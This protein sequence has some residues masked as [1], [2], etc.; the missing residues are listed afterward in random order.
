MLILHSYEI[1]NFEILPVLLRG[2]D[3]AQLKNIAIPVIVFLP[4]NFKMLRT[5]YMEF[6][7]VS[8]ST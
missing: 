3:T 8:N 7:W 5:C 6:L 1:H 4:Q 2:Y